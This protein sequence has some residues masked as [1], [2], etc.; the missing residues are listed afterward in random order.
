[1]LSRLEQCGPQP[2]PINT[3]NVLIAQL[4]IREYMCIEQ[5]GNKYIIYPMHAPVK[6]GTQLY[7]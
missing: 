7:F 2:A 5:S 6:G 3:N 1:M 4:L